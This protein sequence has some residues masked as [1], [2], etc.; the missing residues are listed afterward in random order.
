MRIVPRDPHIKGYGTL[1]LVLGELH[2][3]NDGMN[4]Q[5]Q[6]SV[7]TFLDFLYIREFSTPRS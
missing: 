5:S 6:A 4:V 1:G 7:E 3:G 2:F